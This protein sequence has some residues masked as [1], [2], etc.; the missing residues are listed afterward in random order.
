MSK[1]NSKLTIDELLKFT[2]AL[3]A[4]IASPRSPENWIICLDNSI[5][6]SQSLAFDNDY[7]EETLSMLKQILKLVKTALPQV[8]D[9]TLKNLLMENQAKLIEFFNKKE[10]ELSNHPFGV[11]N[12]DIQNIVRK[13]SEEITVPRA[14]RELSS[15]WSK[16]ANTVKNQYES[17][18]GN[19]QFEDLDK[20]MEQSLQRYRQRKE[21]SDKRRLIGEIKEVS[22][23]SYE[24]NPQEYFRQRVLLPLA[25]RLLKESK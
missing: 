23:L 20:W 9:A 3:S 22:E 7:D 4:H 6:L 18:T 25:S 11:E 13:L 24:N 14:N 1:N 5:E 19:Y 16:I 8:T 21:E 15:D 2:N 10:S 12:P 17:M